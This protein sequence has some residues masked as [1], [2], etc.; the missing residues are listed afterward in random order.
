M[1]GRRRTISEQPAPRKRRSASHGV[2]APSL[3]YAGAAAGSRQR[4]ASMPP[5]GRS[6]RPPHRPAAPGTQA[7]YPVAPPAQPEQPRMVRRHVY[8]AITPVTSGYDHV[9]WLR[10]CAIA[11][12]CVI[13][14]TASVYFYLSK[15]PPGQRWLAANGRE[16][17]VEAYHEVGR[18]YMANG[19]ISSAIWALEIAYL[20]MPDNLE[21]TIDL[22]RAYM[23][24]GQVDRAETAFVYAIQKW[25]QHPDA[26]RLLT[27]IMLDEGRNYEALHL[28]EMAIEQT[29]TGDT[30][31]DTQYTRLL[32]ATPSV[33]VL[34][35]RFSE[36]FS[37]TLSTTEADAT[38]YYTLDGTDPVE[39]GIQ[40]Q[41]DS[42][43]Y[44]SEGGKRLRAVAEKNG[45][46]SKE[47][48]QN[49]NINKPLP[50]IPLFTLAPGTYD[51]IKKV[52]IRSNDEDVVFY[53]TTDGTAPNYVPATEDAPEQINGKKYEEPIELRV[54]YT[55]V[56]A[57]AV[58]SE[59]K[60]SN[61]MSR[62]YRCKVSGQALAMDPVKDTVDGLTLYRTTREEFEAK[63]GP[64]QSEQD[65]SEDIL[66]R[67]TKLI[68]TFG[69]A[70]FLDRGGE[71]P[72]VLCEISTTSSSFS[73]PRETHVGMRMDDIVDK[74]RDEGG[75]ERANGGRLLYTLTDPSRIGIYEPIDDSGDAFK[76]S[77]FYKL[78]NGQFIEIAYYTRAGLVERMEWVQ[79]DAAS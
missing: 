43:I 2:E 51:T 67:Y 11:V 7:G 30:Y 34:G 36:E 5:A 25:P 76:L 72:P 73:G 3:S 35:G 69:H 6:Q 48:A 9:N 21:I 23:G 29:E 58:D 14:L 65:D 15:T 41:K 10:L 22:G 47:Q 49:Y 12:I 68:Y 33:S 16:A 74:F 66:G 39:N 52:G 37:I 26:Y 4:P 61:E 63:Y 46:Y 28:V 13:V 79:F 18:M 71:N 53:Y 60:V 64:P 8:Q 62:T 50:D 32:P 1:D 78:E 20:K 75:E 40:Y 42:T 57:I 24:N 70:I 54:G 19:S 55:T 45:M 56:R 31:F 77:Y 59:G 44:L 38:I 27:G 17:S